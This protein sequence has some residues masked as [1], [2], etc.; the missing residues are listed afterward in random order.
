MNNENKKSCWYANKYTDAVFFTYCVNCKYN[1][2]EGEFFSPSITK[3]L[4]D[5]DKCITYVENE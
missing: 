3:D 4:N 2:K 5:N 1:N